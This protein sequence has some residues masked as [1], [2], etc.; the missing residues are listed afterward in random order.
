MKDP[1]VEPVDASLASIVTTD[2]MTVSLRNDR[3]DLRMD[4]QDSEGRACWYSFGYLV[5]LAA[6][7]FLDIPEAEIQV[8]IQPISGQGRPSARVF[9]SDSLENGAGYSAYFADPIKMEAL[10][11]RLLT[12]YSSALA[13]PQYMRECLTSCHKC[14]RDYHNMRL[15]QFLDWRLGLDMATLALDDAYTP[16]FNGQWEQVVEHTRSQCSKAFGLTAAT[17]SGVPACVDHKSGGAYIFRHPMWNS[18]HDQVPIL[19]SAAIADAEAQGYHVTLAS[20]FQMLRLPN[21]NPAISC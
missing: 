4:P 13:E 16:T 21:Y 3:P 20:I 15:H 10:L 2:A 19:L 5:R 8:G 18:D 14:L 6:S 7:V 1:D 17:F 9:L 12:E 11:R